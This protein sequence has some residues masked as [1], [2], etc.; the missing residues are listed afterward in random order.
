MTQIYLA[1]HGGLAVLRRQNGR[2]AAEL[3]LVDQDCQCLAVDPHRPR[4]LYCGTFTAG[5]WMT[6]D[7]GATWQPLG[8]ELPHTAIM[9]VAV[10]PLEEL[11]GVGLLWAG[12]EPSALFRSEDGGRTW[13]EQPGLQELPSKPTWSFPPRPWTHHVRWIEP[14]ANVA[15]RLFV[16]IELGGVMRSLDDGQTWEDRKPGSQHDCHTLRTHKLAPGTIY[17]TAGGGFAE[18]HDGGDTWRRHDEGR[19][20]HY[21]WGLAVD[22]GNPDTLVVSGSPGARSAH[23]DQYAEAMLYRRTGGGSWQPIREGLPDPKGT[24]A[25]VLATNPAEP[26]VFYAATRRDLYRSGDAGESWEKLPIAWPTQAHFNT[27]KAMVVTEIA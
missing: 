23:N 25:Y 7:A 8:A 18:S 10:S 12:T 13:Q 9:A 19:Q 4:R 14:D 1:L 20:H 22:P 21:L 24:R 15:D 3:S 6:D 17:E 16:G 2:W 11:N 5:L 26:G 27:V